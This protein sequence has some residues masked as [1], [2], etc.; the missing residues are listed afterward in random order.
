ME[1]TGRARAAGRA[2]ASRPRE[3]SLEQEQRRQAVHALDLFRQHEDRLRTVSDFLRSLGRIT[4]AISFNSQFQRLREASRQL[5]LFVEGPRPGLN[6]REA[7]A[8]YREQ[9][10]LTLEQANSSLTTFGS[11]KER[12][13]GVITLRGTWLP[14]TSF[15]AQLRK[16]SKTAEIADHLEKYQNN[17]LSPQR[18]AD[19]H[20][21]L[22]RI[23]EKKIMDIERLTHEFLAMKSAWEFSE[24]LQ[25]ELELISAELKR[26]EAMP[27]R[28]L[29]AANPVAHA[30]VPLPEIAH[31]KDRIEVIARL[32]DPSFSLIELATIIALED[33]INSLLSAIAK[34]ESPQIEELGIGHVPENPYAYRSKLG[35]MIA[36]R[37][38]QLARLVEREKLAPHTCAVKIEAFLRENV[39]NLFSA[40]EIDEQGNAIRKRPATV[41]P[42][43]ETT[44]SLYLTIVNPFQAIKN[45]STVVEKFNRILASISA[46]IEVE[47]T[48]FAEFK[49]TSF[50][51][52]TRILTSLD[53]LQN[54]VKQVNAVL[55]TLRTRRDIEGVFS[56]IFKSFSFFNTNFEK[57]SYPPRA[58]RPP[59]EAGATGATPEETKE[60]LAP[61][62]PKLQRKVISAMNTKRL[63][64]NDGILCWIATLNAH[65]LFTLQRI[66]NIKSG[67]AWKELTENHLLTNTKFDDKRI[68]DV[69]NDKIMLDV[70]LDELYNLSYLGPEN[71][72]RL[73]SRFSKFSEHGEIRPIKEIMGALAEVIVIG[74]LATLP[75][76]GMRIE[77]SRP[78]GTIKFRGE[79]LRQKG[80]ETFFAERDEYQTSEIEADGYIRATS[81]L[82]EVKYCSR[83]EGISFLPDENADGFRQVLRFRNQVRKY[84]ALVKE[85]SVK[86]VEYHIVAAAVSRDVLEYIGSTIGALGRTRVYLYGSLADKEP[87]IVLDHTPKIA[88]P[89]AAP[90]VQ[91]KKVRWD[92]ETWE[93]IAKRFCPQLRNCT[94]TA[95]AIRKNLRGPHVIAMLG[96]MDR[97]LD[98][99]IG[100][101]SAPETLRNRARELK[102]HVF[103]R[104]VRAAVIGNSLGIGTITE[105]TGHLR[106]LRNFL[107]DINFKA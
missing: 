102:T 26:T 3:S 7:F 14:L 81:T 10:R 1:E 35:D 38:R 94:D 77:V 12:F 58:I 45:L 40:V 49:I 28:E 32:A 100:D 92:N 83:P 54:E 61:D 73:L 70:L 36:Y 64:L 62:V 18:M 24:K 4:P 87:K 34:R 33:E 37:N 85:G 107:D 6:F 105:F 48:P 13:N 74:R 8:N 80:K 96:N 98:E 86:E 60:L 47:G 50:K 104:E 55:P 46:W 20:K 56:N 9:Y 53:E 93:W 63:P 21:L 41:E 16:G 66:V 39:L 72:E 51:D 2:E 30:S 75:Q 99:I 101:R 67:D 42:V 106:T 5:N 31:P 103:S 17:E 43:E 82:I 15:I 27:E 88:T 91:E 44:S 90:P 76:Y 68:L 65:Q 25:G 78:M 57:P 29:P 23:N 79:Y 52:R 71:F 89:K 84:A 19:M 97:K 69:L 59:K 22:R 95:I 11:I